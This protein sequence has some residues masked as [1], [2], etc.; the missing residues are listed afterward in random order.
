MNFFRKTYFA[1]F[2]I[3][4][5]VQAAHAQETTVD[6]NTDATNT[7]VIDAWISENVVQAPPA[8]PSCE[9]APEELRY[10]PK[11]KVCD[12]TAGIALYGFLKK[13]V[14]TSIRN[15]YD[16]DQSD[17]EC[18]DIECAPLKVQ[19]YLLG[20]TFKLGCLGAAGS[21]D[22]LK[23]GK[24]IVVQLQKNSASIVRYC[25]PNPAKSVNEPKT[26][27]GTT[28]PTTSTP[29]TST[30]NVSTKG[31]S[32]VCPI[33]KNIAAPYLWKAE[34]SKHIPG[35]DRRKNSSTFIVGRSGS[36][37]AGACLNV[38]AGNGALVHKVG[39][40]ARG[41]G[42]AARYYG[43]TGCGDAKSASRIG[44]DARATSGSTSIYVKINST[45]C[46]KVSN[47]LRQGAAT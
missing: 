40:Y 22:A 35:A 31:L 41:S 33:V 21:S 27:G 4:F 13:A 29:T 10:Y 16:T 37:P 9:V 25:L 7:D 14:K 6:T 1:I 39:L 26:S 28:T 17:S 15:S 46:L 44:T 23:D 8:L 47:L 18:R 5:L 38:Y 32:G 43:G 3:V 19:K 11:L 12:G 20:T 24:Q 36:G 42:Y 34:A 45:T 2:F 30:G